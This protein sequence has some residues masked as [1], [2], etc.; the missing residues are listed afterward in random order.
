MTLAE[1]VPLALKLSIGTIVFAL[2]LKSDA[3]SLTSLLR[4]PGLLARSIVSM[5]VVMPLL[6]VGA[7]RV[8]ALHH[9]V[10]IALIALS[11]SP[12]P[13]L[14]P[15]KQAKAAGDTSYTIGLFVAASLVAIVSIPVAMGVL[16]RFFG[17]PLSGAA[18]TI[19]GIVALLILGP[20]LA[21]VA[22]RAVAVDLADRIQPILSRAAMIVLALGAVAILLTAWRSALDLI[23][24]GTI[25]VFAGFILGGL[26]A[27]YLLGGP[28]RSERKV[29]ALASAARHPGIAL[30]LARINFPDEH[31]VTAA[32]LLYLI[33]GALLTTLFVRWSATADA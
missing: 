32:I 30:A 10:A 5:N 22:I 15:K 26:L 16:G 27:G 2:G 8:C 4:R 29:L 3:A 7:I 1:L 17:V 21:G 14:L 9:A 18:S 20:L 12:V 11:L 24:N 28:D 6:A 13:P 33:L 23:G 31:A 19:A 25:L